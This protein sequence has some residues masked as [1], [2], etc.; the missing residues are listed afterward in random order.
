MRAVGA[1][2]TVLSFPSPLPVRS[3]HNVSVA[4]SSEHRVLG[5]HGMKG[6]PVNQKHQP[7]RNGGSAPKSRYRH[8][9]C[10]STSNSSSAFPAH[11]CGCTSSP[12]STTARGFACSRCDIWDQVEGPGYSP[13]LHS[14]QYAAPERQSRTVAPR[15]RPGVSTRPRVYGNLG[16]MR[17][18]PVR[19][20]R[21]RA[22]VFSSNGVNVH[23][24]PESR[25]PSMPGA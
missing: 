19:T 20:L 24:A 2:E 11:W 14:A 8:I 16:S 21:T 4:S 9:R 22:W 10:S 17:T 5:R 18:L 25:V 12:P 13:R 7:H 1:V 23:F 6:L 15:R 3:V